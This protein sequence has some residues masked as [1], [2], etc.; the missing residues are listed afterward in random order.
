MKKEEIN[1]FGSQYIYTRQCHKETPCVAILNKQ[2]YN[3]FSFFFY[4]I[5]EQEGKTGWKGVGTSRRRE[6]VGKGCRRVN[7]VQILG[8]RVC[9][10]KND[11][12][13]NYSRNGRGRDKGKWWRGLIQV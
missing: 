1:Q 10:R 6:V 11:I 13:G 4:K 2:K 3:F 8:T 7:M 9:K 12:C 5:R